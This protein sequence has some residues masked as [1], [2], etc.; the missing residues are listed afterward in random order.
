MSTYTRIQAC[1]NNLDSCMP[2]SGKKEDN[3]K[4][5]TF[6]GVKLHPAM[7]E[8]A[9]AYAQKAYRCSYEQLSTIEQYDCV[10]ASV[11][12]FN[13]ATDAYYNTHPE[14]IVSGIQ[15]VCLSDMI[16]D[17]DLE[18]QDSYYQWW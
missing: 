8:K 10:M 18:P 5:L 6:R 9:E 4:N 12:E 7:A 14:L 3:M 13:A 17:L 11:D 16:D 2:L 1:I 15:E